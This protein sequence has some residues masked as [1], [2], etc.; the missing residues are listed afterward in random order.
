MTIG[1][2]NK[3]VSLMLVIFL[4]FP[5]I[6]SAGSISTFPD[7]KSMIDD[8]NDYSTSNGTFVVLTSKPLH[9][10]LS[11]QVV[12]GDLPEVIKEQVNRA[13]MYGIYRSFIHTQINDITVTAV[14]IEINFRNKKSILLS[15]YKK[16][17]S[18]TRSEALSLVKKYI[19]VASFSELVADTKIG[20]IVIHNQWTKDFNRIY[21]NDQGSPGLNRFI[22][23]L[24]K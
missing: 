20:T 17:I 6:S 24:S 10:Q 2:T 14:P 11:P 5:V 8:F 1:K 3:L 15:K 18:I 22:S 4:C 13:L 16:T 21:Y 19:N 7:V 12:K 23:E 9:I